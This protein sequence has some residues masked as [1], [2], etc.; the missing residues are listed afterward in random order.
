MLFAAPKNT[1]EG[2][3]QRGITIANAATDNYGDADSVAKLAIYMMV[4]LSWNVKA[5]SDPLRES[6]PWQDCWYHRAWW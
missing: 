1:W 5:V 2:F 4:G 6:P 3:F